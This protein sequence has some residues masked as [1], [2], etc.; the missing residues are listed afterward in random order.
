MW[1]SFGKTEKEQCSHYSCKQ[2]HLLE[3]EEYSERGCPQEYIVLFLSQQWYKKRHSFASLSTCQDIEV[4]Y[5]TTI[6]GRNTT[7]NGSICIHA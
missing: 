7:E 3:I 5:M 2:K 6:N 1:F 4:S